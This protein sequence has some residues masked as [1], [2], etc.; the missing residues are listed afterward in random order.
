MCCSLKKEIMRSER[1]CM[2]DQANQRWSSLHCNVFGLKNKNRREHIRQMYRCRFNCSRFHLQQLKESTS[3]EPTST[4]GILEHPPH[5]HPVPSSNFIPV[6]SQG[7][8]EVIDTY[9]IPKYQVHRVHRVHHKTVVSLGEPLGL[10][11]SQ[12][13][14]LAKPLFRQR[15]ICINM[16]YGYFSTIT[17]DDFTQTQGCGNPNVCWMFLNYIP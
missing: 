8:Q 13:S 15:A 9:G 6:S 7:W 17:W 11:Q 4:Q 1:I 14:V 12:S 10:V 3:V 16:S 2:W 5:S